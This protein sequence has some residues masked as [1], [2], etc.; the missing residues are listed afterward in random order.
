MLHVVSENHTA[1]GA[2]GGQGDLE[3]IAFHLAR[4]R[5]GDRQTGFGV[6]RARRDDERRP[7]P[8]LLVTGLRIEGQPDQIAGVRDVPSGY[9][10]SSPA[11]VPQSVSRW[12][13]RV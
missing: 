12:R 8:T 6:V 9:H 2:A 11:G 7:T 4:Y 5:T 1:D 13:L 10:T 3:R